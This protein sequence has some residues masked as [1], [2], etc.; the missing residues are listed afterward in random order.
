MTL[1]V[2]LAAA[3]IVLGGN[4]A[5]YAQDCM[6]H[7]ESTE[8]SILALRR[9]VGDIESESRAKVEGYIAD[10]EKIVVKARED[11]PR[12]QTPLDR[13]FVIAKVLVAQ[14]NLAAAQLVLKYAQQ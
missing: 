2:A 14:G 1:R 6:Q 12:A 10:A 5:A 3:L 13:S 9:Q 7:I 4:A 8:D 11:C